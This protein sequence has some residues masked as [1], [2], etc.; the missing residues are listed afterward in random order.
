[1]RFYIDEDAISAALTRALRTRS[2]DVETAREL[3]MRGVADEVHL[4]YAA[5]EERTLFSFNRRDY[6]RIHGEWL[7]AGRT[8]AGIVLLGRRAHDIGHQLRGL[9]NIA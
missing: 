1:M 4:E 2:F 7:A 6:I 9:L 3:G 5:S 8:H